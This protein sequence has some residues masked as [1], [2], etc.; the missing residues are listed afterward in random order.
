[1]PKS[2]SEYRT[3]V[4][5]PPWA[6]S[7]SGPRT[8]STA[9]FWDRPNATG[10]V[11]QVPY[12]TMT[13]DAICELPVSELAEADAHLYLW[14]INAYVEDAYTVAR[15]WGFK[16]STLLAWCK[17]PRGVGMG[18]AH[19]PSMEFILFA[20]KGSLAAQERTDTTW[21]NWKRPYVDGAPSHSMKPD[22]FLDMV[23]AVSPGPYAELFARRARF[24]WSYPLGD[25]SIGGVA[26]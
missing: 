9:G 25:E 11:S 20:R 22:G 1:M 19:T 7:D 15:A 6:I 21:W 3:I 8:R 12:P 13:L 10:M 17:T 4:A 23:E 18:G 26:V 5:D 24:G 16:P 2:E 14:T